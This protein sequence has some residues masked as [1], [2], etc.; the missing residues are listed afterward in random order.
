M[1]YNQNQTNFLSK[2][3]TIYLNILKGNVRIRQLIIALDKPT[4]V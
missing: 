1:I 4:G 2:A 3:K